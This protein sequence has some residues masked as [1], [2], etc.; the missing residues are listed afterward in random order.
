MILVIL[1]AKLFQLL[2]VH[3]FLNKNFQLKLAPKSHVYIFQL[4]HYTILFVCVFKLRLICFSFLL[5]FQPYLNGLRFVLTI[6][7]GTIAAM[8]SR[9]IGY[10]SAGA[11]GCMTIAFFAGIGWK[12][13]QRQ[14]TA[15]Q[16]QRQLENENVSF[17]LLL[18]IFSPALPTLL[19]LQCVGSFAYELM[20]SI[21]TTTTTTT[22]VLEVEL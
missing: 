9:A 15:Q 1:Q 7:G 2:L 13:Q 8:G 10:P 14:L 18:S 12:R 19:R 6:L 22:L 3:L 17:F 11:L 21:K 4:H 20:R 16:R 5:I